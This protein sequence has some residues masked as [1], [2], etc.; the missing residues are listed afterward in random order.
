MECVHWKGEKTST[1]IVVM[2]LKS[3]EVVSHTYTEGIYATHHI[4]AYETFEEDSEKVVVDL[5]RA[6]WY[7]LAN[8]TDRDAM[9]NW[10]DSGS[11]SNSFILSRYT[12]DIT[13]NEV[14]ESAWSNDLDIPYLN[15][16]DFPL[17]NPEYEGRPYCYA[18]GQAIVEQFRQYLVKKN[19][20]DSSQDKVGRIYAR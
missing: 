2:S 7:A 18:Y 12:I 11:M 8:F 19:I 3:G 4:N 15:Q 5:V 20:C 9:L 17:I 16:F 1:D 6:P 13:H 10:E 14:V